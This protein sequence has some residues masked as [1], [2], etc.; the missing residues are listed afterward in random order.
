MTVED[1]GTGKP[2][3]SERSYPAKTELTSINQVRFNYSAEA[4]IPAETDTGLLTAYTI[5]ANRQLNITFWK[6]S[7][8]ISALLFGYFY[9]TS[10]F[11]GRVTVD[12][13]GTG[14]TGESGSYL[15]LP[16]EIFQYRIVN[17]LD[18]PIVVGFRM[19]GTIALYAADGD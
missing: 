11:Y 15:F 2:D 5:P 14:S 17:P 4:T 9:N 12:P 10:S 19:A 18:V 6:G 16:G 3:F 8:N 13:F 7:S 1:W